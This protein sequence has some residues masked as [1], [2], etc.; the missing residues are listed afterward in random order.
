MRCG[1]VKPP[2]RAQKAPLRGTWGLGRAVGG[3]W[4]RCGAG[5]LVPVPSWLTLLSVARIT[6]QQAST[7][8]T[9]PS[10]REPGARPLELS[11]HRLWLGEMLGSWA[12]KSTPWHVRAGGDLN[13]RLLAA[14]ASLNKGG[15]GAH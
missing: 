13:S 9:P 4:V 7:G 2:R 5:A 10:D 6:R 12:E 14:H 3:A 8:P 15:T 1:T 11:A